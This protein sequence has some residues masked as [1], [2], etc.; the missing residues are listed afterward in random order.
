MRRHPLIVYVLLLAAATA[1]AAPDTRYYPSAALNSHSN[2]LERFR[3]TQFDTA[4][5]PYFHDEALMGLS[6]YYK[7]VPSCIGRTQKPQTFN[8][9]TYAI[10]V[11][12]NGSGR[13][14]FQTPFFWPAL[15]NCGGYFIWTIHH[16]GT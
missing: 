16:G 1:N 12:V 10:S 15:E 14:I 11:P 5:E 3:A 2:E 4:R 6:A 8:G 13:F 7:D 9:I